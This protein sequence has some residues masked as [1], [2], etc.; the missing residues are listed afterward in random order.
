MLVVLQELFRDP[1]RVLECLQ[2]SIKIA[3]S[4]IEEVMSVHLYCIALDQVRV[5]IYSFA[6]SELI[7]LVFDNSS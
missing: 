7:S 6:K 3:G 2:K 4:C 5:V 1:K